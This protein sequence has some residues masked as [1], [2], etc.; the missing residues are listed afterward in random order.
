MQSQPTTCALSVPTPAR[1][2]K[3]RPAPI[4]TLIADDDAFAC[5]SISFL[6]RNRPGFEVIAVCRDGKEALQS[7]HRLQPD[8]VFLDVDMP[9]LDGFEVVDRILL[10]RKPA[11]IFATVDE[12]A[13]CRAFDV[14]SVDF[15]VKPLT[16]ARFDQALRRVWDQFY[17]GPG[18][19]RWGGS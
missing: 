4:R 6:L 9:G 17:P 5:A 18:A 13:A 10:P 7:I 8:L 15:L 19:C 2:E 3:P 1:A 14:C 12:R 16:R 11:V